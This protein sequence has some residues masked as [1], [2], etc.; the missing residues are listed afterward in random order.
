MPNS[1]S[2]A[3]QSPKKCQNRHEYTLNYSAPNTHRGK[4]ENATATRKEKKRLAR[5]KKRNFRGKKNET[6]AEKK[7]RA[8]RKKNK[9]RAEKKQRNLP[10]ENA[11]LF[12]PRKPRKE[13]RYSA[14]SKEHVKRGACDRRLKEESHEAKA[15]RPRRGKR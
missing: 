13:K 10:A 2:V 6:A 5:K 1:A 3:P 8:P 14:E 9:P 11:L 15:Q 12:A 7:T 4:K